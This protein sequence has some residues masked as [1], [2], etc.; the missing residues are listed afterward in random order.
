VGKKTPFQE[1]M[2]NKGRDVL[3]GYGIILLLL[4]SILFFDFKINCLVEAI[5]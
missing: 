3:I 2:A 1:M 5:K 4:L